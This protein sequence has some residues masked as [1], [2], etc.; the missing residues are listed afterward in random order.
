MKKKEKEIKLP[1]G[2]LR[3]ERIK[4]IADL[5]KEIASTKDKQRLETIAR[6]Q[7]VA[8]TRSIPYKEGIDPEIIAQAAVLIAK[9][10]ITELDKE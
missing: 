10:L 6:E 3:Q 9:A 4:K 8:L 5:K 1:P 2:V 7:A